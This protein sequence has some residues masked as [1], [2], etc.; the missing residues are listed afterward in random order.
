MEAYGFWLQLLIG[1]VQ[2]GVNR[3]CLSLAAP[4]LIYVRTRIF[5]N[6]DLL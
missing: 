3:A 2:R 5:E 1:H 4:P 6:Q